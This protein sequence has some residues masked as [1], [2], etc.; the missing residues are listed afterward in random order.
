MCWGSVYNL[1]TEEQHPLV[2]NEKRSRIVSHHYGKLMQ[3]CLSI[4]TYPSKHL[5]GRAVGHSG[6]LQAMFVD[7]PRSLSH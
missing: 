6:A 3:E 7:K 2:M 5:V 1:R 4:E